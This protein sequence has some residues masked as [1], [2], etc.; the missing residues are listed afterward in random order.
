MVVLSRSYVLFNLDLQSDAKN[1]LKI[2]QVKKKLSPQV[3][4]SRNIGLAATAPLPLIAD[5]N[6]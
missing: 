6:T 3:K 4:Y 2:A 5:F 1:M